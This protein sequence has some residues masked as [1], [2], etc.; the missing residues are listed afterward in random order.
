MLSF[1]REAERATRNQ[2]PKRKEGPP[3]QSF[4]CL[5]NSSSPD[6]DLETFVPPNLLGDIRWTISPVQHAQN[7]VSVDSRS[8]Q[9]KPSRLTHSLTHAPSPPLVLSS[10]QHPN[11]PFE[12]GGGVSTRL[13]LLEYRKLIYFCSRA[14]Q[15][16]FHRER[17]GET[18]NFPQS[19]RDSQA[20]QFSAQ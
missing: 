8:M 13:K 11:W 20:N 9:V 6:T 19:A 17:H 12:W 7:A 16:M 14:P 18:Q 15:S 4:E 5:R 2:S 3:T 10:A 1:E